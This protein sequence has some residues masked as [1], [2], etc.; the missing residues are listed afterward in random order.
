MNPIQISHKIRPEI[1]DPTRYLVTYTFSPND[2]VEYDH[3]YMLYR[4]PH[5]PCTYWTHFQLHQNTKID[6]IMITTEGT[7]HS[8]TTRSQSDGWHDTVWPLPSI[9]SIDQSGYYFKIHDQHE[10]GVTHMIITMLGFIDLY[11]MSHTY[12]LVSTEQVCQ[13]MIIKEDPTSYEK[14]IKER[15]SIHHMTLE[16]KVKQED[17]VI[18]RPIAS[19]H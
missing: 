10:P 12:Q 3:D 14:N 13:F 15:G 2:M 18:I 19:Y 9:D 4:I 8:I 7:T 11:P 6:L 1:D 16:Q 5:S 17:G